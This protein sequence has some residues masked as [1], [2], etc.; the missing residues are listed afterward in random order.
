MKIPEILARISK[1]EG[2][3]SLFMQ[4]KSNF[5]HKSTPKPKV[6]KRM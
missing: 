2:K 1:I 6:I 5:D 3:I 4:G